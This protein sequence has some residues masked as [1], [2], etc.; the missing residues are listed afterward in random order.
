MGSPATDVRGDDTR[1]WQSAR[2]A[3]EAH[4]AAIPEGG[5]RED[6]LAMA[7]ERACAEFRNAA[8]LAAALRIAALRERA[9]VA[10][11]RCAAFRGRAGV[12]CADA[13]QVSRSER[14]HE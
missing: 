6:R 3:A 5:E 1:S 14:K 2:L 7:P 13:S 12:A 8:R 4:D 11:L 9:C 10:A